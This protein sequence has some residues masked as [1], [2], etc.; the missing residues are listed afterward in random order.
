MHTT[1][2]ATSENDCPSPCPF[3][4][5][6]AP[7]NAK[8]LAKSANCPPKKANWQ[9]LCSVIP[10]PPKVTC[11]PATA[12]QP[13]LPSHGLHRHPSPLR[14]RLASQC[15]IGPRSPSRSS[16]GRARDKNWVVSDPGGGGGG[17]LRPSCDFGRPTHQQY[18]IIG[19]R[20]N[21]IEGARKRRPVLGAAPRK[22]G[23]E[24]LRRTSVGKRGCPGVEVSRCS[25]SHLPN[26][27][28]SDGEMARGYIGSGTWRGVQCAV[29]TTRGPTLA[30]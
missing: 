4:T 14:V 16:R 29:V 15:S 27:W 10:G 5:A 26:T 24:F 1:Y 18:Q 28:G 7:P 13:H 22:K 17:V 21:F 3:R 23:W 12:L 19:G 25:P 6:C 20:M 8:S 9:G 11:G 2:C 30:K